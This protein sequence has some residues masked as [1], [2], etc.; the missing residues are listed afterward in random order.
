M[1]ASPHST[2]PG[3]PVPA[4][5]YRFAVVFAAVVLVHIKLGAMVTST[6]SGMAF[7]DWPLARGSFWPPDMNL[8]EMFEFY[9][10]LLGSL[11]GLLSIVM[12]VL[13]HRWDARPW[14][15]K[16]VWALFLMIVVQGILGGLG[17][18]YGQ[19]GGVTSPM[20]S[21]AHGV[22]AHPTL[23]LAAALAFFFSPAWSERPVLPAATARTGRKLCLIA[24]GMILVQLIIGSVARHTNIQSMV[25]LHVF[26]ALLVSVGI[27]I[28]AAH[29]QG[30]IAPQSP[31]IGKLS[32]W[33]FII[34]LLQLTLGFITLGVRRVKDA[35]N[36]E[37][38][39]RSILVSG[40]VVVGAMMFML[41][42]LLLLRVWRAT[43]V[44][45][46]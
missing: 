40:H 32:K 11:V 19:E 1:P 14:A 25:W 26:M 41:A 31:S 18:I 17:V 3:P 6:G 45:E 7:T 9:H 37:Y 36:V 8:G 39:G 20:L 42:T 33:I 44:A 4:S 15:I 30:K 46:T 22:L 28:A 23:C 16:T 5:L 21:V 43:E 12:L 29:A 24:L 13:V 2:P 34:L 35:S 10:R 27:L 38:I